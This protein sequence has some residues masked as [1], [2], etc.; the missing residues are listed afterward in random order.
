ME[1][2]IKSAALE[3]DDKLTLA[4][5]LEPQYKLLKHVYSKQVFGDILVTYNPKYNLKQNMEVCTNEEEK[6]A[7][8]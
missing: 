5:E 7:N 4:P 6:N 2:S 3:I 1:D 8:N